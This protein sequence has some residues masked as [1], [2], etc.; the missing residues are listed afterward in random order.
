MTTN[1]HIGKEVWLRPTYYGVQFGYKT[2][3]PG[4]ISKVGRK[5]I[6]VKYGNNFNRSAKFDMTDNLREK[7]DYH[8]TWVLYWNE[9]D[10]LDEIEHSELKSK[11]ERFFKDWS[12]KLLTTDQ[13]RRIAKIIDESPIETAFNKAMNTTK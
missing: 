6:E 11:C 3:I 12:R 7:N 2:H 1:I 8:T 10:I 4:V 5:Y 9:Q 13:Y